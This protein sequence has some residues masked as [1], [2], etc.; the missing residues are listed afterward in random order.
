MPMKAKK[1]MSLSSSS[2]CWRCWRVVR[3]TLL[4]ATRERGGRGGGDVRS[5]APTD[6]CWEEEK[7]AEA[8]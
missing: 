4:A 7:A 6:V 8:G 1:T 5:T 3:G 2:C